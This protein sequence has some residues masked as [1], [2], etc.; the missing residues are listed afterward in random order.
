MIFS[1]VI[2]KNVP[3]GSLGFLRNN[4]NLFN[5]A[6]T[7]ARAEL[8]VVGDFA[9][10]SHSE[11]DYIE[12]FSKY[13]SELSEII[14]D[15]VDDGQVLINK[16]NEKYP[17]VTN[18]DQVSEWEIYFYEELYKSGIK[19]IPQYKVEKYSLDFA[20]LKKD[21][22]LNIEIDGERYHK[23]W[24]GELCR[25]DIIRNNRLAE[26]GWDVKRFWVYQ[27]RDSLDECILEIKNWIDKSN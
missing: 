20:I 18:K 5:V 7:R 22:K 17:E 2:S 26:Q 14:P 16:L 15:E 27:V 25:R 19:A 11:V 6:I 23:D 12:N 8:I 9:E 21:K 13:V 1:P 4:G 3:K 24:N 10:C